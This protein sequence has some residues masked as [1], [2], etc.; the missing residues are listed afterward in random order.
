MIYRSHFENIPAAAMFPD[1]PLPRISRTDAFQ[2]FLHQR[3]TGLRTVGKRLGL[4]RPGLPSWASN[5]Y[6]ITNNAVTKLFFKY[7]ADVRPGRS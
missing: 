1:N 3:S 2:V 6:F 7:I 4:F 5:L